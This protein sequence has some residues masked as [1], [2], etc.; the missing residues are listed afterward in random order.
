MIEGKRILVVDDDPDVLSLLSDFLVLNGCEVSKGLNGKQALKIAENHEIE[1]A[2]L[3]IGLPD[4][5]GIALIEEIRKRQPFCGIVMLTGRQDVETVVEAMRRGAN[6]F[7]PKPVDFERLLLTLFRIT[8]ERDTYFAR[9]DASAELDHKRTIAALDAELRKK[10]EELT[11]MY[12]ISNSVNAIRIS[13]DIFEKILKIT[14]DAL[15][16]ERSAFYFV[17]ED[18]RLLLY[19]TVPKT[20]FEA[21]LRLKEEDVRRLISQ[22]RHVS[23][24]GEIL[25][26]LSLKGECLGVVRVPIGKRK[27]I[28]TALS[29]LKVVVESCSIQIENRM[30]Y[31]SL[32]ESVLQTLGSLISAINKRD[33][34][35]EGHCLRVTERSLAIAQNMAVPEHDRDSLRMAASVHDLGKVGVPDSVLLKPGRLTEEEFNL[36]KNHSVYGEQILSR[37]EILSRE[38]R[39]VRSHH[40][41]FDGRGYP[42][43]LKAEEIPLLS[44]IIAVA[45]AFDAMTTDR[46]YRKAMTEQEA[47]R[48]IKRCAGTQ[49]DP[50]VVAAFQQVLEDARDGREK[51]VFQG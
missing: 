19:R 36:M 49:F 17:Q 20:C 3:D 10:V 4:M 11:M 23:R 7:L 12:R 41:R 9:R 2:I 47:V 14:N 43:G 32:F 39:I 50:H 16:V 29:L 45:D 22:K 34:Y 44:R 24:G 5:D 27:D 35:T 37:F 40:E 25:F 15:R 6:D 28:E 30:L 46:P 1:I 38:A 51:R 18:G 26:P 42:D 21:E 48:E 8:F 31:E 13:E 33:L